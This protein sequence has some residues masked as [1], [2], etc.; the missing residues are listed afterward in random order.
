MILNC[1]NCGCMVQKVRGD[2]GVSR[3][4]EAVGVESPV[5]QAA[6]AGVLFPGGRSTG[7]EGADC[8]LAKVAVKLSEKGG[9]DRGTDEDERTGGGD[10]RGEFF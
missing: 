9:S 2:E 1:S 3:A 7:G 5:V 10:W 6:G 8:R 4:A